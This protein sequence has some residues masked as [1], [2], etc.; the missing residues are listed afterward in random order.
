MSLDWIALTFVKSDLSWHSFKINMQSY[1]PAIKKLNSTK[2]PYLIL[3]GLTV[4]P[5]PFL[6]LMGHANSSPVALAL[7]KYSTLCIFEIKKIKKSSDS[8]AQL[9]VTAD[10][11]RRRYG[12]SAQRGRGLSRPGAFDAAALQPAL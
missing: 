5:K 11:M 1:S 8:V 7:T 4:L 9:S 2:F 12:G 10:E 3:Q 6:S